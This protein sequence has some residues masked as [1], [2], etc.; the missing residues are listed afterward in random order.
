M[1]IKKIELYNFRNYTKEVVEFSKEKNLILGNNA[2]GKTNLLESVYFACFGK[3][4]R[5][6]NDSEL[7]RNAENLF[8]IYIEFFKNNRNQNIE[9]IVKNNSLKQIKKNGYK[10]TKIKELIGSI[11]AIFFY[12][13]DLK[14]IK[15]SPSERRKFL[16]REISHIS[17]G[18]INELLDYNKII[19]HRN[20]FLKNIVRKNLDINDNMVE[21]EIWNEK[22][23]ISCIKILEKRFEFIIKL[24]K[25]AKIVHKNITS[26][27][28]IKIS[29]ICSFENG[30][31]EQYNEII[32]ENIEL[33]YKNQKKQDFFDDIRKKYIEKL[34]KSLNE[35]L[36][37]GNTKYGIHRDDLYVE[38]NGL[39]S[40]KFASQGQQRT[41][42]LSI[43]MAE[44][45]IVKEELEETPILL[46][47]DV[48]SELD[49]KRQEMLIKRITGFQTIIT[50]TDIEGL[51]D[52]QLIPYRLFDI[53]NGIL[54]KQ[55]DISE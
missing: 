46:L 9:I 8:R 28:K 16:D 25:Y 36:K 55:E 27:E 18:Y 12:P 19:N 37:Y 3:S 2:Q 13:E 24:D 31:L 51:N 32:N 10:L 39:D 17:S 23:S 5:T 26:N 22:L 52:T 21:L 42:I 33:F 47:D 49:I 41:A 40:K 29:Y 53:E 48:M 7:I 20:D 34:E 6:N 4:F 43:K 15:T 45:D 11:N 50:S 54:T 44:I 1:F 30:Y 35:D 38:I 14:I